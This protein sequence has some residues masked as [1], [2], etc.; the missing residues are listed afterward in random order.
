MVRMLGDVVVG[1][2]MGVRKVNWKNE[3]VEEIWSRVGVTV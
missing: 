1:G 3:K 2:W